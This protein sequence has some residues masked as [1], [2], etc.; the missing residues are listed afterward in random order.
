[1]I[2][3]F[4]LRSMAG[5]PMIVLGDGQQTRDFTYVSDTARIMIVAATAENVVGETINIGTGKE[6]SIKQ[7][8]ETVARV[9]E[10]PDA[11]IDHRAPRPGDVRRL[12]AD[13]SK[14]RELLGFEPHVSFESGLRSLKH[15]FA[16]SSE[17]L[18][19]LLASEVE[20]NWHKSLG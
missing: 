4:I 9:V 18:D 20:E 10:R 7:L 8:A 19:E 1:V 17:P 11:K 13:A 15:W 12:C 6:V 2:P 3:K 5:K 14:A 16:A